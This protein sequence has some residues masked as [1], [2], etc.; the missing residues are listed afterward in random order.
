MEQDNPHI[1]TQVEEADIDHDQD[2]TP[3]PE[4]PTQ[5]SRFTA[6]V[7]HLRRLF[8]CKENGGPRLQLRPQVVVRI[9]VPSFPSTRSHLNWFLDRLPLPWQSLHFEQEF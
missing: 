2:A 9:R 7:I 5:D 1:L 3:Q 8:G 4:A 6:V